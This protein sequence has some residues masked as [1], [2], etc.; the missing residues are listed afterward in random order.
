MI[1]NLLFGRSLTRAVIDLRM[2]VRGAYTLRFFMGFFGIHRMYCG[3]MKSGFAM[4]ALWLSAL[5]GVYCSSIAGLGWAGLAGL[6]AYIVLTLWWLFDAI[7]VNDWVLD[8]NRRLLEKAESR[9]APPAASATDVL[10][11]V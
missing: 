7:L 6:L 5:A 2:T 3:H 11:A 9:K 4:M 8:H 1:Y 10:D